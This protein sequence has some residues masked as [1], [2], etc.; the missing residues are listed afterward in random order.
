MPN[1]VSSTDWAA[2]SARAQ[3]FLCLH[4]AGLD[5]ASMIEKAKFLMV[6]GL[7]RAEAAALLGSTDESLR[8]NLARAAKKVAK[9]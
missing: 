7:P 9:K 8:V 6:L 5:D 4:Q 3:A 1:E 2:V